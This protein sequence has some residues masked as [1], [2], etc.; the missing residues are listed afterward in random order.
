M[1]KDGRPYTNENRSVDSALITDLPE[2]TQEQIDAWIKANFKHS[3]RENKGHTSYGLKHILEDDMGIYLTNNQFKDAMMKAGFDPVDPDE[4]NWTYRIKPSSPALKFYYARMTSKWESTW[5]FQRILEVLHEYWLSCPDEAFVEVKMYFR[6]KDGE[7]Q[8]KD[9][10]WT[11]PYLL[12]KQKAK[13][14][15]ETY[16]TFRFE[17]YAWSKEERRKYTE[18]AKEHFIGA[19]IIVDADGEETVL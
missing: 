12:P 7:E 9:I 10:V 1:I 19:K 3:K 15:T 5:Q 2:G 14:D 18:W 11:S 4:L 8:T 17:Q 16:R 6:N 13:S